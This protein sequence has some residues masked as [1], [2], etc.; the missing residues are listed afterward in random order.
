MTFLVIGLRVLFEMNLDREIKI[1]I[2][3][4]QKHSPKTIFFYKKLK[5]SIEKKLFFTTKIIKNKKNLKL[6]KIA[7]IKFPFLKWEI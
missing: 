7:T 6:G 2:K 1:L 5:R 4:Y 3:N